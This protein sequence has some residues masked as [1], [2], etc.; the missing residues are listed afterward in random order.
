MMRGASKSGRHVIGQ[1]IPG[2]GVAGRLDLPGII[3][4]CMTHHD[5][6]RSIEALHQQPA[7]LVD[8]QVEGTAYLLHALIAQPVF[9]GLQQVGEQIA[10]VT[11]LQHA[12]IP[13][14]PVVPLLVEAVDLGADAPD[15]A[16]VVPRDPGLPAGMLEKRVFGGQAL[17]LLE[18][19]RRHPL[20]VVAVKRPGNL[21]ELIE[22]PSAGNRLDMNSFGV[23][24]VHQL[25][26]LVFR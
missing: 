13:D 21:D 3:R 1:Q 15:G 2:A 17:F 4:S 7:F 11:G 22:V 23:W 14:F 10:I 19:Q 24:G 12:E 9:G 5:R 25:R 8:R 16:A 20:R 26:I 6:R 18:Q